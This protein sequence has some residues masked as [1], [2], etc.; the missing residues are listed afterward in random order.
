M[1]DKTSGSVPK[2]DDEVRSL[3]ECMSKLVQKLVL[4]I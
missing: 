1:E 2:D 3:T 4:E